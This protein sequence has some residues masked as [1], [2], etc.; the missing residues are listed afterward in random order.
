MADVWD[1]N[2]SGSTKTLD[3][4]VLGA[5]PQARRRRGVP[6]DP[7]STLRGYGYRYEAG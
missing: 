5:A 6:G 2:W 7:I 3:M 1:E 4:H